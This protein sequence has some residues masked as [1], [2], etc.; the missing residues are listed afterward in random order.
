MNRPGDGTAALFVATE[1]KGDIRRL[2][3]GGRHWQLVIGRS[4]SM[5]PPADSTV[6]ILRKVP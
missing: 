3:G 2:G 1:I 5:A 4:I 6:G